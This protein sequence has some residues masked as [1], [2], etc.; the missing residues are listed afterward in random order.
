MS[1]QQF[2]DELYHLYEVTKK[3]ISY[4]LSHHAMDELVSGKDRDYVYFAQYMN[5]IVKYRKQS[6]T[7]AKN[8]QV[9]LEMKEMIDFIEGNTKEK[10]YFLKLYALF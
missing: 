1:I 9:C 2:L 8:K 4:E 6:Q 5:S 3:M 10:Q 7:V